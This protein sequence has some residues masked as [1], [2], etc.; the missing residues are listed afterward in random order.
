MTKNLTTLKVKLASWRESHG[1]K[2]VD[3]PAD[4]QD[5]VLG[6]LD[7][8][9]WDDV[10]GELEVSRS[11]LSKWRRERC[12]GRGARRRKVER[13]AG[14]TRAGRGVQRVAG[15]QEPLAR[16][17][18]V[19]VGTVAAE[20]AGKD[21]AGGHWRV[22]LTGPQGCSLRLHGP[23]DRETLRVLAQVAVGGGPVKS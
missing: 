5:E 12:A 7:A 20:M 8:H 10:A 22:E 21:D 2:L 1:G 17:S 9:T 15:V 13:E 11:T 3:V 6:Q 18:F 14:P 19:E 23:V 16:W 4:L